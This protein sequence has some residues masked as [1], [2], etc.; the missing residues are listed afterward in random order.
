MTLPF[1]F[2]HI[3][4]FNCENTIVPCLEAILCQSGFTL[5]SNLLV[6]VTDNNSSDNTVGYIE[7]HF[8]ESVR[9]QVIT[10]N[11]GFAGAHNLGIEMALAIKAEAGQV[12][13]V[14]ILNPD[15]RLEVDALRHLVSAL[16]LDTR[17]GMACP[18]L[19]RADTKLQPVSPRR[20]D[21]TGMFIT[22]NLRHFDRGSELLY[23]HQYD[24]PEY[25]FG[26]SGAAVLFRRN[27]LFDINIYSR[28]LAA[29]PME[30]FDNTFF[31][32]RE[33][34]DLSWRA[35]WLGWKCR[36]VPEAKGY[37][38]RFVLPEIRRKLPA[39]VN[40]F[41]VRNRFLLQCNN[42]SFLANCHCIFPTLFR[43]FVVMAAVLTVERTSQKALLE[44][45]KLVPQALTKRRLL[46]RRKRVSSRF[47]KK[48]FLW[49]PMSEKA[50]RFNAS[51][52]PIQSVCAIVINFNSGNRLGRC[53]THL[54]TAMTQ[55]PAE[56]HLKVNV[57][58]N[59][60]SDD[61]ALRLEPCYRQHQTISFELSKSNLGFA[62]AINSAVASSTADAYLV[63]NPDVLICA[64]AILKLCE[65]LTNYSS[66][67]VVA[68]VLYDQRGNVQFGYTIR[69]FPTLGSI[70]SELFFLHRLW[71]N[72][73]WTTSYLQTDDRFLIQY[74]MRKTSLDTNAPLENPTL[75][76][77]ID[78]PAGAC[79]LVRKATF[80]ELHGF[81]TNFWPAWFEDVDFCKRLSC[82]QWQCAVLASAEAIHEGGYSKQVLPAAQFAKIW[83][84]NLDRY[85]K[86]HGSAFD[87]LLFRTML[88][89]ALVLRRA[90][91][92]I[93][94]FLSQRS[95]HSA[96]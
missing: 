89:L 10:T 53:L 8:R 6:Q 59:A 39:P 64:E 27:F 31:A 4:T 71:P 40:A 30:V 36:Y 81:D 91:G 85:W 75:P 7:K 24:V 73:P 72:N 26:A 56:L 20:F 87:Y 69:S 77:L 95:N 2:V 93:R 86:K 80:E 38:T 33:D 51:A 92:S 84:S 58:D 21:T 50:L 52:Q 5:H 48:W 29:H 46:L 90:V 15:L 34:A 41:G 82:T 62:G 3:V 43:N 9:L 1:T 55:L 17:A 11:L 88:P 25:V 37:H 61:S 96:P 22:P 78:Q 12:E 65:A 16:M 44:A 66:L 19:F 67:G 83:L 32:Y 74:L 76:L 18:Q 45:W 13:F 42:F 60:S 63:L 14:V 94:L 68:P 70:L 28:H 49:K 54:S 47:V 57:I 23:E 79:L 35:Q